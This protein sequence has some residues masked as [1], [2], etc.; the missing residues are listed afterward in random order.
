M[1]PLLSKLKEE[2]K[3]VVGE[4]ATI[5]F[6]DKN[7]LVNR[8]NLQTTRKNY[9]AL[10]EGSADIILAF[11]LLSNEVI[12]KMTTF[13]K[14][15]ILFGAVNKDLLEFNFDK[16]VS[17]IENFTYL[18]SSQSYKEDLK[19]LKQLTDFKNLAILVDAGIEN[20][21]PL[22]A[23]FDKEITA[24]DADYKLV[25]FTSVE[26]ILNNIEGADTVYMVGG[27]FLSDEE[28]SKLAQAFI[29][30]KLPSFTVNGVK[31]VES[32]V[33]GTNQSDDN[34]TTFFRR[35]ALTIEQYIN[36]TTLETLPV[37]IN[38][39]SKLT[40]NYN[41]AQLVGVP[42]KYSLLGVTN[43][44]GDFKNVLSQKNYNLLTVIDDA[45]KNN[46]SLQSDQREIQL[47]TQ[48]LKTAKS[49]YLPALDANANATYLDPDTAEISL[50]QNPEFSTDGNL[51]LN[52]TIFS[53]A[54]NA[55]IAIQKNLLKAEK[56][57]Y[58]AS[59]LDLIFS[60]S[61]SYFNAL[62][63]KA[64]TQIQIQNL[65]LTKTNLQIAE[66]NFKAGEKGKSDV[67]RFRSELAQDTQMMIEAINALAKGF[68]DL[69]QVMNNPTDFEI[70]V[71]E[72]SLDKGVLKQYNYDRFFE[73]LDNPSLR[74]PFTSFLIAEAKKNAPELKS[75]DYN[76][77]AIDRN[78]KLNTYG[79]F[80]PT[81][82]L[83][84][85][86]SETFS[87]AGAGKS[88]P[89]GFGLVD[90]SYN[91][92]AN[93]TI[94][95]LNRNRANINLKT[96][97]I[98]K[99]QLEINQADIELLLDV[100]VRNGILNL[101]NEISN[102]KLSKISE[103]AARES[104]ELTQ[105]SYSSGA[106]AIIELIDSQNNFLNARL[107]KAN[108][109]YNYLINALQLERFLGY[110]FVLNTDADNEAFTQRFFEFLNKQ[111]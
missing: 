103:E 6:P 55:N 104:L 12:G 94:P 51:T 52:Q 78:I 64:N 62:I 33:M 35:I 27:F 9:A 60:A 39:E 65:E 69:N 93:V 44:V 105:T 92:V 3:A 61:N 58:N 63:L 79:R 37:K 67:L 30:R 14:P 99:E 57:N 20:V 74:E 38:N 19:T 43:F 11:G 100:N 89:Q 26:D 110:Y 76:L 47:S 54:S 7:I 72:A 108:A 81:L 75:L 21:L 22:K 13:K 85:Q 106:V 48:D 98:Q 83:Q 87:R 102:I 31:V 68:I 25:P 84:A 96:S 70:D 77:I 41:T 46:L 36:G 107:S 91:A 86:Y 15:T 8:L 101:V 88:A 73:L 66:L 4:D 53:E 95:I 16:E 5:S 23:T 82:S 2:I 34:L 45:I 49:D 90:N 18:V 10:I 111:N 24:L 50:G 56:E 17:G 29:D 1:L 40:I 80:L 32:G 42:I 97:K 28:N 71:V 109:I 59:Q